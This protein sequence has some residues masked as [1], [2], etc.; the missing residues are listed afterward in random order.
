MAKTPEEKAA[1]AAAKATAAAAVD[2]GEGSTG[3]A[4]KTVEV[5]QEFLAELQKGLLDAQMAAQTATAR[6]DEAMAMADAK[7]GVTP[8]KEKLREKKNHEPKFHTVRLRKYPIAGDHENLGY[9]V[10]WTNRGAYQQVDRS[11]VTP[12]NVDYIDIIFLGQERNAEGKLQAE[13]VK[14]LDF[15]NGG[16]QVHCKI[17]DTKINPE[18]VETGEEIDVTTFDPSHGLMTTGDMIDGFTAFTHRT[19]TLAVPGI[20]EPVVVDELYVN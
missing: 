12:Q 3:N 11:G 10:G 18:K 16:I 7:D 5:P 13:K 8:G 4:P 19:Y 1:E 20:V 17:L 6:A 14:L 2:Q 15:L 9:V